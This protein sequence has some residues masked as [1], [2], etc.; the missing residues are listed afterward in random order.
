MANTHP[1]NLGDVFKHLFLCE[2]LQSQPVAYIDSHAGALQYELADVPDPGA[3]G[4]WDFAQLAAADDVLGGSL[5]ARIALPR[6]G[7][8]DDPGVY[9]GSVG[10]ADLIL[11]PTTSIIAVDTNDGTAD[12]LEA[13]FTS[14]ARTV[15][16]MRAPF[17]GQDVVANMTEPGSLALID[18]FTVLEESQQ[19]LSS[20]A[21]FRESALRG[22]TT[23]LWYPLIDPNQG[24][25][26]VD[27][28]LRSAGIEPLH[29]E[30]RYRQ[31]AAGLWGCGMVATQIPVDASVRTTALWESFKR[32]LQRLTLDPDFRS[33][34]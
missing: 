3:G 20:I 7:T 15:Q 19:G 9:L 31:K 14:S 28:E 10:L 6:A 12:E 1:A 30:I 4:I 16:V 8:P 29:F 11:A 25:P 13:A 32:S 17:E 24:T 23:Y 34:G 18:P 21:A 26:W 22:A 27:E 5:Y 33:S 2:A